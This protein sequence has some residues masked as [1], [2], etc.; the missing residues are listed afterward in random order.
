MRRS[1]LITLLLAACHA[2]LA[3]TVAKGANTDPQLLRP[4]PALSA[5]QQLDWAVGRSFAHKPWVSA[6][7]TTTARDGLGPWFNANSCLGCHPG[8]GQG[9]LPEHGP[10]LI[11]RLPADSPLGSQLQDR[12][13]PGFRPEG[14]LVWDTVKN[15]VLAYRR[16]RIA[17]HSDLPVSPRL[18]PELRGM[19]ALEQLEARDILAWADPD[20]ANG[21][22]ISG[23]PALLLSDNGDTHLGR[24]GWKASQA[25]LAAQ[26]AQAFAEDMGI[27]SSHRR[28][29][30]CAD[31]A[32]APAQQQR[33]Q[34]ASGAE[35]GQSEE[36]SNTLFAAVVRYFQGLTP[37]APPV[38]GHRAG[39]QIFDELAC[40]A[41]HRPTLPLGEQTL[42]PYSDLLLHDMG[43]GLADAVTEGAASGSEWR[44]APLWGLGFR[45]RDPDNTRLLHDGRANSIHQAILWHGGEAAA[46]AARYQQLTAQ[47]T[48]DLIRFLQEL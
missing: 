23:R 18:A 10:G 12:A 30:S 2:P 37:P 43:E 8:N 41:C 3:A 40:S 32:L 20:D 27:D 7:A 21:D 4:A 47:Q 13:L 22:G 44:T 26:I 14:R 15:G 24:Y 35:S 34:R 36:I 45:S 19:A 25:S 11:L 5:E 48:H 42:S 38:I 1:A 39:Q 6:P 9:Q 17:E 29:R 46:S 33:C 28:S 31:E 16:Y